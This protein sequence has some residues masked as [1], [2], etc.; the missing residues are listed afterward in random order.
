[1]S[2]VQPDTFFPFASG[3]GATATSARWRL[4]ARTWLGSGVIPSYLNSCTPS[5]A[6][7][8]ASIAPGAVWI[9][10]FYG[11]S[12]GVKTITVGGGDGMLVARADPNNNQIVYAYVLGQTTP[13]QNLTDVYEIP[14]ARVTSGLM[15]DIRQFASSGS[16]GG[17][18]PTGVILDFGGT[19]APPGWLLTDGS[20]Y[21]RGDYPALFGVIGTRHGA[22]DGTHFN[23]PDIRGRVAL[24]AGS[25]SGLTSRALAATGG[26]ETVGLSA[27]QNGQHSHGG[28]V[29][30]DDRDHYH[31]LTSPL[32]DGHTL[33]TMQDGLSTQNAVIGGNGNKIQGR[34][35][36]LTDGR[37]T[38]HLHGINNDGSGAAHENMPP[39]IVFTKIIKT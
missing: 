30:V 34:G 12:A 9:D 6:G 28:S 20:S 10:G 3:S 16:G 1:M 26:V 37:S 2:F 25:G 18:V 11:E 31:A 27:A 39:F 38:G 29:G 14:I 36:G 22:V 23:V 15:F 35:E 7:S 13:T 32:R 21:V 24:G 33:I 8:V 5:L 19:L 4:M 17:A